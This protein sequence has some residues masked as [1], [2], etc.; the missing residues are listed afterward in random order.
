LPPRL[1]RVLFEAAAAGVTEDAATA[2][3]ILA[4]RGNLWRGRSSRAN[5]WDQVDAFD[6]ARAARFD[7]HVCDGLG[8]D[9]R[10]ARGCD[11]ARRQLL[12]AAK[13]LPRSSSV[14]ADREQAER[15]LE[16]ALLSGFPDRVGK[17]I[18]GDRRRGV[19]LALSS[20]GAAEVSDGA[21]LSP[22]GLCLVLDAH[23]GGSGKPATV[24]LAAPLSLDALIEG[25]G[26]AIGDEEEM[27]FDA[28]RE[29]VESVARLRYGRVVLEETRGA[30]PAS[31]A[32]S[33][34]LLDEVFR[35]GL[36]L[37]G[38]DETEGWLRRARFVAK[39]ADDFPSVEDQALRERLAPLTQ[40]MT[41]MDELTSAGLEHLLALGLEPEQRKQLDRLAPKQLRLASGQSLPIT[42]PDDAPPFV[43][44]YLQ[45]F[46]GLA[47][48]PT[49]GGEAMVVKLWAPNGRP[50]QVTDDLAGFWKRL[51]PELRRE[52][53]RRY[54]KHHW[55]E[56][57]TTAPAIRLKRQLPGG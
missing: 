9:R 26:E 31:E 34:A 4:E 20:G 38:G 52:L 25:Q 27:V 24:H 57:P 36:A 46:F 41:R 17:R 14:P 40:G 13:R 32:A 15:A 1:G 56:D 7:R 30:A 51:Y 22:D 49:R 29:R 54:P 18:R 28:G 37:V 39:H 11:R 44:S 8:I 45:D 6:E 50:M 35:R 42:Y 5:V 48:L 47:S 43:E 12:A 53:G 21:A 16:R 3:A 19:G 2:M 33:S 23:R 10:R 55:P